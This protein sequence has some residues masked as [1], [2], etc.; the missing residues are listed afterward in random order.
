MSLFSLLLKNNLDR[1]QSW[2]FV[3]W[4]VQ[5]YSWHHQCFMWTWMLMKSIPNTRWDSVYTATITGRFVCLC[6]L[7]CVWVLAVCGSWYFGLSSCEE[8]HESSL[9][10]WN[11][12]R[13]GEEFDWAGAFSHAPMKRGQMSK[14]FPNE[15]WHSLNPF[16]LF[17]HPS[18]VL[19]SLALWFLP[20]YL[21]SNSY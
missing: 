7:L 1:C 6:V 5:L 18:R 8:R 10:N 15:K 16:L 9:C 3:I 19:H 13:T 21:P 2:Q 17:H 11:V 20:A 4:A 14:S 12:M